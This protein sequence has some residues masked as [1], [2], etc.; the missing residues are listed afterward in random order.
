M[1][2]A[3]DDD[4]IQTLAPKS[5][6]KPFDDGVH[7]RGARS[8]LDNL[9]ARTLSNAIKR[10][11][12][13][14]IA[15]AN[16]QLGTTT[17]RCD[18]TQLLR[19]PLFAPHSRFSLDIR[20]MRSSASCCRRGFGVRWILDF[21]IHKRR[22][23][24]RCHRRT[25]SG[26][27]SSVASRQRGSLLAKRT[28]KPL[29]QG[30]DFACLSFR[31]AT[32]SCWQRS[33]FSSRSSSLDR[34][35]SSTSPEIIGSGRRASVTVLFA[36][37]RTLAAAARARAFRTS[38]DTL[39][40]SR[41]SCGIARH[42]VSRVT[43]S[44]CGGACAEP[45]QAQGSQVREITAKGVPR[46]GYCQLRRRAVRDSLGL[47]LPSRTPQLQRWLMPEAEVAR[48]GCTGLPK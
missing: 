28:S 37:A 36:Q 32:T 45:R 15:I 23:P 40:I 16:E 3:Q 6:K 30:R 31:E 20:M 33:R 19:R 43:Q 8:D 29:S 18:L 7:T 46:C 2:F 9:D 12:V 14:G 21:R 47:G 4:V 11:A 13:F 38:S 42:C 5:T 27:T 22:N 35:A 44:V 34:K 26:F 39:A 41:N 10:G 25:V 17:E 24:S 1:G 48:Y